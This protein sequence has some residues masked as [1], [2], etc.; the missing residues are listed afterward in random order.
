MVTMRSITFFL[1]ALQLNFAPIFGFAKDDNTPK[2]K[3]F[4]V[5]HENATAQA[6]LQVPEYA[7]FAK[8]GTY[9]SNFHALTNPSQPNYIA[10]IAGDTFNTPPYDDKMVS[11]PNANHPEANS[12]I[13]DLIE[14]KGLSW[15]VYL[16]NYPSPGFDGDGYLELEPYAGVHRVTITQGA[17]VGYYP[18]NFANN[19]AQG[20]IPEAQIIVAENLNATAGPNQDFT[21]KIV[22]VSRAEYTPAIKIKNAQEAGAVGVLIYNT[23]T[24]KG[25]FTPGG[26]FYP[27]CKNDCD[28]L[29]IAAFGISYTDGLYILDAISKDPTTKG[30]VDIEYSKGSLHVYVRKHNPFISFLNI[31]T[32]PQRAL[33]LVNSTELNHDIATNNVPDFAFYI[34]NQMNNGHDTNTVVDPLTGQVS[35]FMPTYSGAAFENTLGLALKTKSFTKDRVIVLTFDENDYSEETNHIYCAFYGANVKQNHIVNTPYNLYNLLRTMEESL[36]VGTLGRND[37]SCA[38][39]LG[40]RK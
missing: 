29:Q 12:T 28:K 4:V 40:W 10:L 13:I 22:L 32:N 15:K 7:N 6:A 9:F 20:S 2:D 33:K 3:W 35:V 8:Q 30:F 21:G 38:P 23:S 36:N 11:F 25:T 14:E 31:A 17:A 1:F 18:A 27:S 5:I 37:T 24:D 19:G 16:E 39:M 26:F 34:P